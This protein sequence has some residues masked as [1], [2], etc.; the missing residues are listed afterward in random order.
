MGDVLARLFVN[1][2][3]LPH[4]GY[5]FV[6]VMFL[7]ACYL[8]ILLIGANMIGDGSELLMLIPSIAGVV[9]SVV[10]PVLGAVPDG[11][12]V[13]FSGLGPADKAQQQVSVGVG[14]LAGSTVMLLTIPWLLSVL[15]GRVP[16]E[17]NVPQYSKKAELGPIG[18]GSLRS[19]GV[20]VDRSIRT[21]GMVMLCTCVTYLVVEIPALTLINDDRITEVQHIR[22]F[23][24]AGVVMCTLFFIAYIVLQYRIAK[25]QSRLATPELFEQR[26]TDV[27]VKSIQSGQLSL[28]GALAELATSAGAPASFR[29][30]DAPLVSP[31]A[32][33]AALTTKLRAVVRP[34]F[35]RLDTDGN[36]TLSRDEM[37][38][39]T[40]TLGENPTE[41]EVEEMFR[42]AD[43]SGDHQ[44][45][46]DEF[47]VF[48]K[49][50]LQHEQRTRRSAR[51]HFCSSTHRHASRCARASPRHLVMADGEGKEFFIFGHPV[52]MSPSPDIHNTGFEKNGCLHKYLRCDA[53]DV[54]D[55]L[56]K[57]REES[58][59]GGSVT[60]PH[61]EAVLPEM[62]ELSDSAK[63][64]GAVNTITKKADGQL[65]GDNTDWLGIKNMLES[66]L[67]APEKPLPSD[68]TC[69]LCGAGGTSRAAAY[70]LQ[71]MGAKRVLVYNRTFSRGEALAKEFGFE[72]VENLED[73][74]QKLETLHIVVNTLP[75]N[76]DFT[77]PEP[78]ANLSARRP[79]VLEA[80]YIPRRTA[81]VR[82]ALEAGCDVVE[83]VE[84]LFEQGCAQC[85]IWTHKPAPR[86]DIAK[87]LLQALFTSGSEHPAFP[88][89]EPHD[90]I[91]VAL[92][93][94][95]GL[96]SWP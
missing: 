25:A 40:M 74:L 54:A 44:I 38:V 41:K 4:D 83:G 65:A 82:Q 15:G 77:L 42:T 1:I 16:L 90:V 31:S 37:R 43:T 27:M 22:P 53:P 76:T 85:E 11:A 71:K 81:F 87:S 79:V 51:A 55:V 20:A 23:A 80:A 19:T 34:F 46:F 59:G 68:L 58:C 47:V 61:K 73:A 9:G 96:S 64:I 84:M 6:Q 18:L 67:G 95:S 26:V 86:A 29:N 57:L 48:C 78:A 33:D 92:L 8:Y 10:L 50:L 88:K 30:G 60:I 91:P 39:L 21:S 63:T 32:E 2:E 72:A 56:K 28:R 7:G 49:R 12:I 62:S 24:W 66:R 3:S 94:E 36:G 75:G 70:A 14:A 89:M 17:C 69:L 52:T 5:G 35:K 13:L 93:K 45:S